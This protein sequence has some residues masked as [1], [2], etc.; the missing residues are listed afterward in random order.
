[1]EDLYIFD[2]PIYRCTKHSYYADME[3]REKKHIHE[4]LTNN[5]VPHET[6]PDTHQRAKEHLRKAFGGPWDFNQIIG[7]IRLYAEGSHIGG[8]LWWVD[9]KR[10]RRDTRKTFYLRTPSNILATYFAPTDNSASIFSETLT[11]LEAL[12]KRIQVEG[13]YVDLENF[14]NLGPFIKWRELL[15]SAVTSRRKRGRLQSTRPRLG[16]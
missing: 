16:S 11:Q 6:A 2:V 1:M 13:H 4:L 12:G 3:Q 7:W 8:Q 14:R 15:N 10:I 5:G 9:A